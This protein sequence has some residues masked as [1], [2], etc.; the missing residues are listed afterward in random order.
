MG[1]ESRER[2]KGPAGGDRGYRVA[3]V[4]VAC[5][6]SPSSSA[7]HLGLEAVVWQFMEE[8]CLGSTGGWKMAKLVLENDGAL[9]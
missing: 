7:C 9:G 4:V 3:G 2:A 1:K 8:L 5:T 6:S